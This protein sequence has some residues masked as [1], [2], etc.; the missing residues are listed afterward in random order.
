MLRPG[1]PDAVAGVDWVVAALPGT[2]R[3]GRPLTDLTRWALLLV[4]LLLVGAAPVTL[5]R[6]AAARS[7]RV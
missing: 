4:P 3:G 7:T 2:Y 1:L 6:N 5:A